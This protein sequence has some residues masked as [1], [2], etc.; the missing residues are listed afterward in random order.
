MH[1]NQL[2]RVLCFYTLKPYTCVLCACAF[3]EKDAAQ[4]LLGIRRFRSVFLFH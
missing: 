4:L 3:V 1:N 2:S